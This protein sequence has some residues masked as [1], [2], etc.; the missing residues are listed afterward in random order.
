MG[1]AGSITVSSSQ[2]VLS[3]Y[4]SLQRTRAFSEA[5]LLVSLCASP[6]PFIISGFFRLGLGWR[7]FY[8]LIFFLIVILTVKMR[9][10]RIPDQRTETRGKS[11]ETKRTLG[12]EY[13]LYWSIIVLGIAAEWCLVFWSAD[14]LQNRSAVVRSTAIALVSFFFVGQ[15]LGRFLSSRL[16]INIAT[17]RLLHAALLCGMSG[18][19]IFWLNRLPWLNVVG[20]FIAGVGVGSSYPLTAS[21]ALGCAA[22]QSDRAAGQLTW[23]GGI[24][25]LTA[26]FAIGAL[27]DA[28]DFFWAVS[29][30]LVLLF[31]MET[32][33]VVASVSE[34]KWK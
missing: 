21:L 24:A 2:A 33:T 34:Q 25:I 26:P 17:R 23:G 15:A 4:H 32:L 18:F 13:R 31:V 30:I 16:S 1:F 12:I 5:Q 20:L 3:D 6:V 27:A 28:I 19:L 9:A 8:Y 22:S 14:Y 10:L 29:L 11:K 7:S